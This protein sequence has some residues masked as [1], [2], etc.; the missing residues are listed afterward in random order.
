MGGR[1]TRGPE[2]TAARSAFDRASA[3]YDAAATLQADV[4]SALI[5]RL[6]RAGAHPETV[7]D[8]GAGTGQGAYELKSRYPQ[9]SVVAVDFAPRMLLEAQRRSTALNPFH[10]VCADALRLPLRSASVDVVFSS[11]MLQWCAP[12]DDAFSEI[13][14]V[15]S[16]QGRLHFSTLGPETLHELRTAW[17]AADAFD[18]VNHFLSAAEIQLAL[19]R[20]GL[21]TV[22]LQTE[23][24][25]LVFADV[26]S[27]MRSLKAIGAQTV[28][29]GRSP[30]LMGK[31]RLR[32]MTEAYESFRKGGGLP[33]TYEVIFGAARRASANPRAQDC[34]H[35]DDA[36]AAQ[37]TPGSGAPQAQPEGGLTPSSAA[38][39]GAICAGVTGS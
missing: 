31:A 26:L 7:L 22:E 39:V 2:Y 1:G 24:I 5:E 25:E 28:T 20:A 15:L 34:K 17:A 36:L 16:P 11:L 8:L 9:A 37:K 14:R 27:V 38:I 35:A 6:D 33:M 10:S 4:R 13:H 21:E 32:S 19:Q 18:H 29:R 23:R 12:L 30:G 3:T